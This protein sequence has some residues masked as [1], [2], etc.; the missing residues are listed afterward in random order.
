MT[1]R[2]KVYNET[3]QEDGTK[4]VN[5]AIWDNTRCALIDTK[6]VYKVELVGN[7]FVTVLDKSCKLDGNKITKV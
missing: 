7:Q 3:E 6:E 2:Y 5:G 4:P 1:G